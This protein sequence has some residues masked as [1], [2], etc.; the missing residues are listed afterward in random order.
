MID[1]LKRAFAEEKDFVRIHAAEALVETGEGAFVTA[2]LLPESETAPPIVRVGIWRTL[3][4]AAASGRRDPWI[5]KLRNVMLTPG[6]PDRIHAAESLAK[7][8]VSLPEDRPA[9]EELAR[10]SSKAHSCHA[11]WMLA[12]AG[13]ATA[14]G[15]LM[16]L[17]KSDDP[18]A[19]LASGYI[20]GRL[21]KISDAAREQLIAAAKSERS[22]SPAC[23]YLLAAAYVS[24]ADDLRAGEL[25]TRLMERLKN[26]TVSERYAAALAIGERGNQADL[27]LLAPL[28]EQTG[29][30]KI[31]GAQGSLRIL[32]RRS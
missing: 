19:R 11:N 2:S 28:L 3:G 4:A 26:G 24:A 31:G 14:E 15:R 29:D 32:R 30:A 21:P 23:G 8:G 6:L 16:E 20:L 13:D 9:I 27:P 22:D 25:K 5:A 1:V 10:I 7:L 17:M 12:L 18:I